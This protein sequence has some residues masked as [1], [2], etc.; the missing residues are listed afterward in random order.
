MEVNKLIGNKILNYVFSR[1]LTYFVQFLNA[2]LIANYLGPYYLGI[3]G[4]ILLMNQYFLQFNFGLPNSFVTIASSLTKKDDT[5]ELFNNSIILTIFLSFLFLFVYALIY[6][7][8]ITY[9]SDY[10]LEEYIFLIILSAILVNF[11]MIFINLYRIYNKIWQIAFSQSLFP[12]LSLLIILVSGLESK[13]L[14]SVLLIGYFISVLIP[15]LLFIYYSPL[16]FVLKY[17]DLICKRIIKRGMFLFLYNTSFYLIMIS[18][19]T[20]I[21]DYY[22]VSQFGLFTFSFTLANSILLLFESLQFLIF[23][24]LINKLTNISP[25]SCM[26]FISTLRIPYITITHLLIHFGI[27]VFPIFITFFPNYIES[28]NIFRLIALTIIILTLKFG[29]DSY[30]LAKC[31]EKE[32]GTAAFISLLINVFLS[33]VLCYSFKVPLDY[34]ILATT[35]AY[36]LF[37]IFVVYRGMKLIG[38]RPSISSLMSQIFPMN[39]LVPYILSFCCVILSYPNWTFYIIFLIYILLNIKSFNLVRG[40]LNQ[41]INKSNIADI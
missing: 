15:F 10:N 28:T 5:K 16:P 20:I 22:D 17:D 36:M 21:S 18:S 33:L 38:D 23:P 1:Y 8:I 11:N 35:L 41:I 30:L 12:I 4:F 2:L 7:D 40:L 39:Y 14:V 26:D 32:I 27:M 19:R 37:V 31:R 3:W 24:K 13:E 9:G 34:A 29:F 6:F 25:D